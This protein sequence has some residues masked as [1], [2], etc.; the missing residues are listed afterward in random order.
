MRGCGAADGPS[1][2]VIR[3]V[4]TQHDDGGT[5]VPGDTG[6][7]GDVV[8]IAGGLLA[9]SGWVDDDAT[10]VLLLLLAMGTNVLE[11]ITTTSDDND[12]NDDPTVR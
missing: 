3:V 11:T 6:T 12:D 9:V 8:G 1:D 5:S 10:N 2:G 7:L 4:P